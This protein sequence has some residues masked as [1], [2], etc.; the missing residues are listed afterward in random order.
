M[1]DLAWVGELGDLS[2]ELLVCLDYGNGLLDGLLDF[3]VE[4]SLEVFLV[5]A[6]GGPVRSLLLLHHLVLLLLVLGF[7]SLVGRT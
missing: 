4:W 5:D 1:R 6:D 7:L 3:L 2:E